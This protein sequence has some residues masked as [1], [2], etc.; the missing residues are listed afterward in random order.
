LYCFLDKLQFT[1][2]K[3]VAFGISLFYDSPEPPAGLFDEL[4]NLPSTISAI[5]EG[6]FSDFITTQFYPTYDR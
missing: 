1:E 5:F 6:N 4:L 3:Q 2:V